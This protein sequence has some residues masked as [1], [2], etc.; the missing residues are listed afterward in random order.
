MASVR[1]IQTIFG[2][3]IPFALL[4]AGLFLLEFTIEIILGGFAYIVNITIG[5]D[6]PQTPDFP[7]P[8]NVLAFLIGAFPSFWDIGT[9]LFWGAIEEL[10]FIGY[11]ILTIVVIF[12]D[13]AVIKLARTQLLEISGVAGAKS[14]ERTG[15]TIGE[16][17]DD[18]STKYEIKP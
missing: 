7:G 4:I 17:G 15:M 9:V 8:L 18:I 16:Y 11:V 6:L 3:L 2:Y 14:Q 10:T 13:L 5:F 12:L 1:L